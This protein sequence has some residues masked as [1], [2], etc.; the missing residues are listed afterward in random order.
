VNT[1]SAELERYREQ[2]AAL[3]GD[4]HRPV[5]HFLA[6]ANWMND[7]NGMIQWDGQYHLFYQF[8]P[9][10]PFHSS[11]H[12]GHAVSEDLLHWRDL[13]IALSPE[14]GLYDQD[15]CWSGCAVD[16]GG[17]PLL[18]YTASFP[19][20]VA[21]AVSRD[22][23]LTWEKLAENPLIPG[24]P[25][26]LAPLAGGHFRDPFIWRD[27]SGASPTDGDDWQMVIASK[28][29][30]R[31][32][33]ILLYRSPDLRRWEYRGVLL[34]GDVGQTEPFWQGTMWECPNLLDYGE[35]QALVISV[36]ATPSRGL[37]AVYYTGAL[38]NE[39]FRPERSD[40]LVHGGSLYAPQV[41]RA[42]DGRFI[43]FGWLLEGRSQQACLEA[44]WYGALSLP[45]EL[46][47]LPDGEMAVSPA[48]ELVGLRRG[49]WS[50]ADI[51]LPAGEEFVVPGVQGKALEIEVE[52]LPQP[53]ADFGLKV[54]CSPGDGEYTRIAY[55]RDSEQIFV[56][57]RRSSLDQRADRNSATMPV[58]LATGESQRWR[59]FVDH[60]VI[61]VF[62]NEHL[63]LACRVYPTREDSRSVRL[64]SQGGR[65]RVPACDIWQLA[66]VWPTGEG[67]VS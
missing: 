37:Y 20:A 63:C 36:Q 18:V 62:I 55:R 67:T 19:Q 60:S 59:V 45:L 31:G 5:Y 40:I 23:L 44:G 9:H 25:A 14:P 13:P 8:N 57:R 51:V 33:Q 49:Q 6:P 64:F 48:Q 61:E 34:A 32:G 50:G 41:M 54:L 56:E 39:R 30:G 24:P 3:A 43:M 42:D 2:R 58:A 4:P 10:G 22:G 65:T 15:G 28:V 11:I 53:G 17:A 21:A 16:D 66:A 12:W 47:L 26:E 35:R 27:G 7:P 52:F 29:E 46:R 38:Q 1:H